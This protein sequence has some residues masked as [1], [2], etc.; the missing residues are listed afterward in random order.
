LHSRTKHIDIR[1]HYIRDEIKNKAIAIS[2]VESAKQQADIFTKA[3]GKQVFI[4]L[5]DSIM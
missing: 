1:H 3:L 4:P 5:R 2:Y